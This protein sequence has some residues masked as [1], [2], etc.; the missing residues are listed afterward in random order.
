RKFATAVNEAPAELQV[1]RLPPPFAL[2][3]RRGLARVRDTPRD[4]FMVFYQLTQLHNERRPPTPLSPCQQENQSKRPALKK[5]T[6]RAGGGGRAS[7]LFEQV[8]KEAVYVLRDLLLGPPFVCRAPTPRRPV[9]LPATIPRHALALPPAVG[10]STVAAS[11]ATDGRRPICIPRRKR[12]GVRSPLCSGRNAPLAATFRNAARRPAAVFLEGPVFAVRSAAAGIA[13][14]FRPP[15]RFAAHSPMTPIFF[16]RRRQRRRLAGRRRRAPG[17]S[18]SAAC[19]VPPGIAAAFGPPVRI[20]P[21]TPVTPIVF[22]R[23]QFAVRKR[24][25]TEQPVFAACP[26]RGDI[27]AASELPARF[28]PPP[29]A[30]PI[31][32]LRRRLAAQKRRA[33]GRPVVG[34]CP[35]PTDVVAVFGRP[36]RIVPPPPVTPIIILR[37]RLAARRRLAPRGQPRPLPLFLF[38][39][40]PPAFL[41]GSGEVFLLAAV[42]QLGG[43]IWAQSQLHQGVLALA[44]LRVREVDFPRLQILLLLAPQGAAHELAL[45]AHGFRVRAPPEGNLKCPPRG[46]ISVLSS[47]VAE[48]TPRLGS[49]HKKPRFR[50]APYLPFIVAL[51]LRDAVLLE[52][53]AVVLFRNPLFPRELVLVFVGTPE[54]LVVLL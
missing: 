48:G 31:V 4:D 51:E 46:Y 22:L 37:R 23:R 26:V 16:L 7:A 21:P 53:P 19:P 6:G 54:K 13:A 9:W 24:C 29:P 35:A 17:R 20:A 47:V 32:F 28:A 44:A 33:P 39:V 14:A 38:T 27:V 50:E 41:S 45:T 10:A 15:A 43:A 12:L 3:E 49:K 34:A 40:P 36:A 52:Q 1:D 2:A 30:M 18:F 42:V 5:G 11:A 8:G 25:A